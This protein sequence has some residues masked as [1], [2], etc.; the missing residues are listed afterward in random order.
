[1]LTEARL[2]RCK[3]EEYIPQYLRA[4]GGRIP[5][6]ERVA[7][8]KYLGV[9]IPGDVTA[10]GSTNV[11]YRVECVWH[12]FCKI[13]TALTDR[14]VHIKLR[15]KLF[16]AVIT[17]CILY[18]LITTPMLASDYEKIEVVQRKMLRRIIGFS[19]LNEET[20][21][22][23]FKRNNEKLARVMSIYPVGNWGDEL[24]TRKRKF[25]EQLSRGYRNSLAV[26]AYNWNPIGCRDRK[27]RD[28]SFQKQ[29]KN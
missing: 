29:S 5:V 17:P 27:L 28:G 20:W 4:S 15:L 26:D 19:K 1:M 25:K 14:H 16:S 11:R 18:S 22:S 8:H 10:R 21:E 6:L 24:V 12:K 13:K 7:R 9:S 3:S 2:L 23:A